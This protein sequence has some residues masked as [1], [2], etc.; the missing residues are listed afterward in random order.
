MAKLKG[1]FQRKQSENLSLTRN[2]NWEDPAKNGHWETG[3][4]SRIIAHKPGDFGIYRF[5]RKCRVSQR[6]A[7]FYVPVEWSREKNFLYI[8]IMRLFSIEIR[9]F[10]YP[11]ISW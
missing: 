2:C 8:K 3:K 11:Y 7:I 4:A 10:S 6:P 5:G 1:I 9:G